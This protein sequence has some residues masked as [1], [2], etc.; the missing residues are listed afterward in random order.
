MTIRIDDRLYAR[1][2][3]R[4]GKSSPAQVYKAND[5]KKRQ[6]ASTSYGTHPGAMDV[7]ATQR[8]QARKDKSSVTRFNC[9]KKGH[10]KRE[11]RRIAEVWGLTL[12]QDE[13]GAWRTL[14]RTEEEAE[15]LWRD[16]RMA[17]ERRTLWDGPTGPD[18]AFGHRQSTDISNPEA[19]YALEEMFSRHRKGRT[20]S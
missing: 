7:D 3:Q 12:T 17:D 16:L 14:K 19:E 4:K 6:H 11:C 18:D 15:R 1:K 5:R 2:Q 13:G 9:G 10:F 20:T 8:D